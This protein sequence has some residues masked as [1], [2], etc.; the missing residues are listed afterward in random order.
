MSD[1][2]YAPVLTKAKNLGWIRGYQDGKFKPFQKIS[3]AE[4]VKI[5]LLTRFK[6][7]DIHESVPFFVDTP[8]LKPLENP[9]YYRYITFAVVKKYVNGYSGQNEQ[10]G[11]GGLVKFGP[12][13][14]LTWDQ[15]MKMYQRFK[16]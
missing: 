5:L 7:A 13:D 10:V 1:T 9:W 6:D 4:A 3:R 12:D 11:N 2:W 16:P 15:A 8:D 14:L